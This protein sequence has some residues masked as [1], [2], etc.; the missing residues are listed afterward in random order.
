MKDHVYDFQG[1]K[2]PG[3]RMGKSLAL[4][5]PWPGL[6]L[7]WHGSYYPRAG[8][9]R[10]LEEGHCKQSWDVGC[11]DHSMKKV[12]SADGKLWTPELKWELT[13]GYEPGQKEPS[14]KPSSAGTR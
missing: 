3:K 1:K 13:T 14:L 6:P 12:G 5:I 8:W 7:D 11:Y 9:G 10:A 4:D 2:V